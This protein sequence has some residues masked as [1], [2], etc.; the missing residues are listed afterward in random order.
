MSCTKHF[1]NEKHDGNQIF[2]V[3]VQFCGK[4]GPNFTT[5]STASRK[6]S[7]IHDRID[8][9]SRKKSKD[10]DRIKQRASFH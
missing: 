3:H 2:D 5:E 4:K 6:K 7:K 8:R 9:F 1:S 10:H